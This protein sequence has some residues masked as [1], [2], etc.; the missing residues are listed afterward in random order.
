MPACLL[1]ASGTRPFGPLLDWWLFFHASIRRGTIRPFELHLRADAGSRLP[2]QDEDDAMIHCGASK[3]VILI[4]LR[5]SR[6]LFLPVYFSRISWQLERKWMLEGHTCVYASFNFVPRFRYAGQCFEISFETSVIYYSALW[7]MKYLIRAHSSK[8]GRYALKC[9]EFCYAAEDILPENNDTHI[10]QQQAD[11]SL[12][13][14]HTTIVIK[15]HKFHVILPRSHSEPIPNQHHVS[16]LPLSMSDHRWS[17]E[18]ESLPLSPIVR[19]HTIMPLSRID[20]RLGGG[21]E[22]ASHAPSSPS[23]SCAVWRSRHLRHKGQTWMRRG[24][25]STLWGRNLELANESP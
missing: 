16:Y 14:L 7:S 10:A 24:M 23:S 4:Q 13:L 5:P 25:N 18:M 1:P 21:N 17:P 6:L 2:M 9:S 22:R 19:T 3:P 12:A 8:Y 11:T 15:S 20:G